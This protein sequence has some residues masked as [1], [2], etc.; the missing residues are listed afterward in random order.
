MDKPN[1]DND[2]A[3]AVKLRRIRIRKPGDLATL[4]KKMWLAVLS[5]Q[6][7]LT[8]P[9]VT[10]DQQLRAVHALVQA[11]GAYAKLL[12]TTDL[13]EQLEVL[14]AEM[15]HLKGQIPLRKVS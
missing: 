8:S 6:T 14:K 11:G 10:P 15:A 12:E 1:K 3:P 2:G 13:Q 9:D 7:I 4:K 5:A